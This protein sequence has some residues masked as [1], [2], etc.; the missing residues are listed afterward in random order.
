MNPAASS[1]QFIVSSMQLSSIRNFSESILTA[2]S[3]ANRRSGLSE[4]Q[5]AQRI[6]RGSL[7]YLCGVFLGGKFSMTPLGNQII[8]GFRFSERVRFELVIERGTNLY[9]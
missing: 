6:R 9:V 3:K 7:H 5:R 2:M 8:G 1:A 4:T